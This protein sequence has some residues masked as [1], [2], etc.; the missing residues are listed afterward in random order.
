MKR[1]V[2]P[3][4]CLTPFITRP[5]TPKGPLAKALIGEWRNL[6]VRINIKDKVMEADSS[7]WEARLQIKPIRTHFQAD[8]SYYSEYRNL[9][10]SIVRRPSGTWTLKGDSLTMSQLQPEHMQMTFQLHIEKDVATFTGLIDFDGDG[11]ADNLYF[12]RQRKY[13]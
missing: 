10:D 9:Q 11:K 5:Q 3:L 8:G 13:Q 4:L 6:Y 12:G 7:N 1:Y 2:L